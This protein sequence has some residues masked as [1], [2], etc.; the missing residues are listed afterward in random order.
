MDLERQTLQTVGCDETQRCPF[1]SCTRSNT[2]GTFPSARFVQPCIRLRVTM[3]GASDIPRHGSASSFQGLTM[4]QHRCNTYWATISCSISKSHP[5]SQKSSV[6]QVLA[7]LCRYST[8]IYIYLYISTAT[9]L[10][11]QNPTARQ[12]QELGLERLSFDREEIPTIVDKLA[13]MFNQPPALSK[14][15]ARVKLFAT[16]GSQRPRQARFKPGRAT[17]SQQHGKRL[18]CDCLSHRN[19]QKTWPGFRSMEGHQK[20]TKT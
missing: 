20:H 4:L 10:R 14:A 9:N 3:L 12:Q 13:T 17:V 18:A 5:V 6:L 8:Y 16:C 2:S 7:L 11:L 15:A 19:V 1:S